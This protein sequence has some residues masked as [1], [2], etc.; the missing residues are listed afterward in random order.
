MTETLKISF[1][2][3]SEMQLLRRFFFRLF[4]VIVTAGII[5]A[6]VSL[7]AQGTQQLKISGTIT[8]AG[9]GDPMIG[10]NIQVK[11]TSIGAISDIDGKYSLSSAVDQNTIMVFSFIGYSVQEVPVAGKSI[12]NV[13]L[14]AELQGLDEVVVI[15][16]G[17]AKK[18]TVTGSVSSVVGDKIQVSTYKYYELISRYAT[19]TG[20]CK[21]F[22]RART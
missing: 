9:T 2:R 3:I 13:S 17:T 10:V 1:K 7:V 5:T 8:D 19:G 4:L 15:G 20:C 12:I 21:L 18:A 11:G 16:Y 6:P 14:V 22:R